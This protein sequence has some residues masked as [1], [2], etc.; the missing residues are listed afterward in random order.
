MLLQKA[1]KQ[2]FQP[3]KR[4]ASR[5][6]AVRRYTVTLAPRL[7]DARCKTAS[8]LGGWHADFGCLQSG[9]SLLCGHP[10]QISKHSCSTPQQRALH[11]SAQAAGKVSNGS[12]SVSPEA[13]IALRVV[14][15][16][17]HVEAERSYLAVRSPC[18][19]TCGDLLLLRTFA[20][21]NWKYLL[22]IG[23]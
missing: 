6:L 9:W 2:A 3:D 7:T 12:S 21:T 10:L 8:A 1:S 13:P 18:C 15:E 17:L 5:A 23:H 16:P 22:N 20:Y 19:Q 11:I 4:G 14:D